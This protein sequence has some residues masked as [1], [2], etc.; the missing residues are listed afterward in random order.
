MTARPARRWLSAT[1]VLLGTVAGTFVGTPAGADDEPTASDGQGVRVEIVSITPQVLVPG[2][3]LTVTARLTNEGAAPLESVD[4]NLLVNRYRMGSRDEVAEWAARSDDESA[5]AQAVQVPVDEPLAPDA[6]HTV[7]F[8]L[9][10]DRVWLYDLPGLWGPR[11]LAVEAEVAGERVGLQRS[12]L[13]WNPDDDLPRVPVSVLL[14]FVGP[15]AVPSPSEP[16]SEPEPEPTTSPTP[17]SDETG[18]PTIADAATAAADAEALAD[19][20]DQAATELDEL[21]APDGRLSRMLSAAG[22]DGSVGIAVDPA[23]LAA[24]DAAGGQAAQ[25]AD[26]LRAATGRHQTYALAWSDP[27]VAAAAHGDGAG[28]LGLAADLSAEADGPVGGQPLLAWGTGS[29]ADGATLAAAEQMG[30]VAMIAAAPATTPQDSSDGLASATTTGGGTTTTITPDPVLTSLVVDPQVDDPGATPATVAQRAL[31]EVALVAREDTLPAGLLI[32]PGRDEAPSTAVLR[33]VVQALRDAPWARIAS[34]PALLGTTP[35]ARVDSPDR[36]VASGE[37]APAQVAALIGARSDVLDFSTVVADADAFLTGVDEQTIAPLAVAW[38][39]DPRTRTALVT[40]TVD[41]LE[42]RTRG[43]S[44]V[45]MS[46]VTVIAAQGDVR[47]TVSNALD[48]AATARVVVEPRKACVTADDVDAVTIDAGSDAVVD[49]ALSAHANCDVVIEVHLVG[50]QGDV[51]QPIEFSARVSPR[52]ESVGTIVVGVL[53]AIGMLLGIGRTVR[54]G[55]SARRGART[56]AEAD[57]PLSLPVLGGMP[58][59][60]RRE[61]EPQNEPDENGGTDGPGDEV[62]P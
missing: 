11:G 58:A 1:L 18:D 32:A 25:W 26:R 19:A 17:T 12:Y 3:D 47:I 31:A 45:P 16:G 27:D 38:R 9:P 56:V 6:S 28:L 24:A 29:V 51:A 22:A 53:L 44:I 23:V 7:T 8:T 46:D 59:E 30:A 41:D 52:I 62:R 49:V 37:L 15:G 2:E 33:A 40:A 10:A 13:L 5:G 42:E 20:S 48:V 55:Q 35:T 50:P 43:L 34:M 21:V 54:R 14:P 57:A 61:A 60:P 4:A 36:V 39:D